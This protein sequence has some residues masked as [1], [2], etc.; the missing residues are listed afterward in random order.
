MNK[1]PHFSQKNQNRYACLLGYIY[2]HGF[3]AL[4]TVNKPLL[5]PQPLRNHHAR[6]TDS[7]LTYR[8]RAYHRDSLAFLLPC[9]LTFPSP[10]G[11]DEDVD[12]AM[13]ATALSL[14]KAFLTSSLSSEKRDL[15]VHW[16]SAVPLSRKCKSVDSSMR[17]LSRTSEQCG[18]YFRP[19]ST[20]TE[21]QACLIDDTDCIESVTL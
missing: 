4:Q 17:N 14:L 16:S 7:A 2:I 6:S 10:L 8:R 3:T 13:A 1:E 20:E 12:E 15:L 11:E 9:L 19:S 5:P 21:A 18:K